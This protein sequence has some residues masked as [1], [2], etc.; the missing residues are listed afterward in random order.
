[1]ISS[2]TTVLFVSHD[3]DKIKMLCEKVIWL[4]K[5]EIIKIGGA[6]QIC[7]TYFTT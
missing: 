6:E 3:I 7:D 4:E 5:G 1:M 2:G